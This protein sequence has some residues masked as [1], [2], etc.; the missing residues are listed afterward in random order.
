MLGI[1]VILL[2]W[3]LVF[4]ITIAD[5]LLVTLLLLDTLLLLLHLTHLVGLSLFLSLTLGFFLLDPLLLFFLASAVSILL[6][7]FA[8]FV[9]GS[10]ALLSFGGCGLLLRGLFFHLLAH[11]FFL[12]VTTLAC[13]VI[14]GT[15]TED[16]LHMRGSVNSCSG[17]SEQGLKEQVCLF[18]LMT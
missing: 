14:S 12:V 4:D 8:G 13:T 15:T 17:G 16:L 6:L 5:Q 18:R 9:L 3:L 10:L 11:G 2:H 1:I 7:L